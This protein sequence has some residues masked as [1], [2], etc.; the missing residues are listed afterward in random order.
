MH[1]LIVAKQPLPGRAKTRLIPRFGADGAAAL[2]AAALADTFAAARASSA[3]R[4]VVAFDGDPSGIVPSGF[5]VVA[6]RR[7]DLAA[8]LGGAWADAGGPG[9]Q[10][11]MDTPQ[12]TASD[13]DDAFDV[14]RGRAAV[15]GPAS[16]G[17]WWAIGLQQP[18]PGVFA[19]IATSRVDTGARQHARLVELGLEPALLAERRD[20][21][22]P[23]DVFAVAAE[24]PGTRF[25][26]V[27]AALAAFPSSGPVGDPLRSALPVP[28]GGR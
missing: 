15:L 21:D 10:I 26:E 2:A 25:A 22:R 3:D 27:A 14:L 19:G 6:Q 28:V 1:L 5:Q 16:D 12:L 18:V 11:G 24:A 17:G 9:L 8:R 4:V 23:D 20:V 7:G 13:L